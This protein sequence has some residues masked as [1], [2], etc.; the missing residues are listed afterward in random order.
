MRLLSIVLLATLLAGCGKGPTEVVQVST[1]AASSDENFSAF[2]ALPDG[3]Y[4]EIVQDAGGLYDLNQVRIVVTNSDGSKGLLPLG[5]VSNLPQINGKIYQF[6]NLTYAAGNNV[7]AD[8][9]NAVLN[10]S[11]YTMVTLT[12]VGGSL[13]IRV[14]VSNGGAVV[15]DHSL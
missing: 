2:Y 11:L 1:T 14:Q 4:L 15:F 12:N 7:K 5:V 10:G 6:G 8:V 13:G 3:G 9:G